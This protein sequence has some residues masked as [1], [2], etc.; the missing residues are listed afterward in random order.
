FA[1]ACGVGGPVLLA[2]AI[3]PLTA[4]LAL[5]CLLIYVLAYTPLKTRTTLNTLVGAVCGAI[6]PIMGWTAGAGEWPPAGRVLGAIL[7]VWQIPHFLALAWMYREDYERGGFRMLPVIDRDG[8]LTCQATVL[9]SLTLIPVTLM[10]TIAGAT[11]A[12]YA[13]GAVLLGLG[14]L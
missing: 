8:R 9:Y 12:L 10:L 11:G 13:A 5:T 3:N 4:A 6:P 2:I 14:L 7:F 1:M